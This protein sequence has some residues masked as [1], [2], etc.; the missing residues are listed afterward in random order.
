[1]QVGDIEIIP[2][3]DGVGKLPSAYIPN[4]DWEAHKDLLDADGNFDI[5]IGCFVVRTNDKTVLID[6]GLGPL[7]VGPY[8]TGELPGRLT[9]AGIKPED[10]DLVLITHLHID[11][12]GWV[13]R[14][15]KPYFP[16]AT[17]RFGEKDLDQFIR[18]DTPDPA[19]SQ[20]IQ[21]LEPHGL[22]ETISGDTEVVPGVSTM[23]TPGHTLGHLCVVVSS[24]DQR[25]F[26][27]GDAITC[28]IQLGEGDVAAISEVDS[29]LAKRT[30]ETLIKELE[31]TEDILVAAHFPE[32]KFG[33]LLRGEGKRYF[34]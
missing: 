29:N 14:D 33:R 1:V 13:V 26:L 15:G 3:S 34:A 30:R 21:T 16:N 22:I 23:H 19:A 25:A 27:L 11:H 5:Q 10:I 2:V 20:M 31:G 17:V 8:K 32:L 6:A 24:G 28:P 4:A 9:A 18:V 7:E 12:I